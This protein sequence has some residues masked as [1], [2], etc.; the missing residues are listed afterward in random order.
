[1]FIEF[2]NLILV[3]LNVLELMAV[4]LNVL[5]NEISTLLCISSKILA[6]PTADDFLIFNIVIFSLL[7]YSNYFINFAVGKMQL[8]I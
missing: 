5:E 1:M 6:V 8:L 2:E 4:I 7:I 3:P